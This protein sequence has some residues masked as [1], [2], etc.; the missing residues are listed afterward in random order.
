MAFLQ[1]VMCPNNMARTGDNEQICFS[2]Y[3]ELYGVPR[4]TIFGVNAA[5]LN[6]W[7]YAGDEARGERFLEPPFDYAGHT[8]YQL[9]LE[10]TSEG[11]TSPNNADAAAMQLGT[12]RCA[13]GTRPVWRGSAR[14]RTAGGKS[15]PVSIWQCEA[16]SG[17][18][19]KVRTQ[20][21]LYA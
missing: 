12:M 1:R 3:T 5:S 13:P 6:R 17:P 11:V 16:E 15:Q 4:G 2:N 10:R 18:R 8:N 20:S 21:M 19:D 7:K 9:V 14:M